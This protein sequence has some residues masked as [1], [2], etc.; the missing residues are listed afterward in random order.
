MQRVLVSWPNTKVLIILFA[1]LLSA[2]KQTKTLSSVSTES[3]MAVLMEVAGASLRVRLNEIHQ[4]VSI[5]TGLISL[6]VPPQSIFRVSDR[7]EK[8]LFPGQFLDLDKG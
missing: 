8:K 4:T 2:L 6:K 3:P 1:A 7:G 5:N